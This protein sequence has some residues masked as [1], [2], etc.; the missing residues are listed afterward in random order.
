MVAGLVHGLVHNPTSAQNIWQ[1]NYF[2]YSY[3]EL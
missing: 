1:L 2:D 3:T